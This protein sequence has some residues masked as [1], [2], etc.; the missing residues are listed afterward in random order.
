MRQ[1]ICLLSA[2]PS[3]IM[4]F[5]IT[6]KKGDS[7]LENAWERSWDKRENCG[8]K[9]TVFAESG[10]YAE[11]AMVLIKTKGWTWRSGQRSCKY[12]YTLGRL[13]DY[14]GDGSRHQ[15]APLADIII[16]IYGGENVWQ[17]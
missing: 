11:R 1:H 16:N 15:G 8:P 4:L 9:G 2:H 13:M 12:L 6:E 10:T 3:D 5:D 7:R 14:L 17:N